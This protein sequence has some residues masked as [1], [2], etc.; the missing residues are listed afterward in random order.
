MAKKNKRSELNAKRG[1]KERKYFSVTGKEDLRGISSWLK[2][3]FMTMGQG[4]SRQKFNKS[5]YKENGYGPRGLDGHTSNDV[6]DFPRVHGTN[7]V[8]AVSCINGTSICISGG[9][10]GVSI[11]S[12]FSQK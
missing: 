4:Q 2:S 6:R 1:W 5:N 9:S 10:G 12:Y 7:S 8:T 3:N 11:V